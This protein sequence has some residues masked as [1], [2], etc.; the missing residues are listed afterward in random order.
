[1]RTRQPLGLGRL[2]RSHW[3]VRHSK[4]LGTS[5]VAY[6]LAQRAVDMVDAD[7]TPALQDFIAAN[8]TR[9]FDLQFVLPLRGASQ[10]FKHCQGSPAR[11][12]RQ[13]C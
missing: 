10:C 2:E 11:C 6:A 7:V 3:W 5:A 8:A 12:Q 1:M 9:R 4:S 13:F